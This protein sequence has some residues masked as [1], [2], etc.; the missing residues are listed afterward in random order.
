MTELFTSMTAQAVLAATNPMVEKLRYLYPEMV[1]FVTTVVVMIIGLSPRRALRKSCAWLSGAGLVA[2]GVTAYYTSPE[3]QTSAL[4]GLMPFAKLLIAAVGLLLVMVLA[5]TVDRDFEAELDRG[6]P[7]D[8]IRSNRA[9]FY[10]FFL[11]S[12]TGL[13]LCSAADDL[14]WLFLALELTSL[15]TYVMVS[16]STARSRSQEAGVKYFFLGALGA[17]TFLYGFAMLYGATGTT[18]L[19]GSPENPGIAEVLSTQ[20]AS[21][22]LSPLALIGLVISIVGVSFKVAAVPM[23]F[24]TPDVYQGAS[25]SV[26]A[27]LAFV[28]KAAGFI[29]LALLLSTVGWEGPHGLPEPLRVLLWVMAALTMTVGNVMALLQSNIKRM[30]AYSSIAHTG[31]MLVGLIVGPGAAAAGAPESSAIAGN[32]LAAMLF[33]LLCYGFMNLGAFAVLACLERG[34]RGDDAGYEEVDTVDD[35]R[36]LYATHPV[37]A[38]VMV[39]SALSLLGFPVLLGFVGKLYLFTSAI[40]ASEIVLV[41]VMGLNSA[42]GAFYYLRLVFAPFLTDADS[43]ATPHRTTA[44]SARIL[45]ATVSAVS[46]VALVVPSANLMRL[47]NHATRFVPRPAVPESPRADTSELPV[48][49]VAAS[50]E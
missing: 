29:T 46:V 6:R 43:R 48:P 14:I 13:M 7:F 44:F 33:Y 25:T 38:G 11:F 16:I 12:L 10:A 2:A 37:L 40:S 35:L 26:A 45:A 19:F 36:G 4:P 28:P 8:A 9:E 30:L 42:I 3:L 17:A 32:G 20:L 49:V 5:G 31:Y 1:L 15:P 27:F 34:G 39:L 18:T 21:G 50:P 41:V 47:C 23:H 22:G 24:Y